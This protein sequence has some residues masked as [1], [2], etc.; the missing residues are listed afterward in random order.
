MSDDL[1]E[2][3]MGF[4]QG[5]SVKSKAKRKKVGACIVTRNDVTLSGYNGTPKGWDNVCEDENNVTKPEV[6]H[7]ELNCV[8]KAAREGISLT[9][10]VCYVTL[11]P[12]VSCAAMLFQAGIVRLVYKHK[13]RNMDGVNLLK[14]YG[15]E[16]VC[17]EPEG[18]TYEQ[19]KDHYIPNWR[20]VPVNGWND[21]EEGWTY[22]YQK[23]LNS[24]I[25]N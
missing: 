12:C 8:L 11:A 1:D 3:Y 9:G 16:V 20:E 7:A 17:S 13:Y 25:D 22:E 23:Y 19:W 6:I 10:S 24:T 4:A 5:I 15:V 21:P 14:K 18:L 2:I